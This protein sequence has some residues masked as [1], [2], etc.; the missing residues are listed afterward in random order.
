MTRIVREMPYFDAPCFRARW[1]T[2][3]LDRRDAELARD[4]RQKAVHLAVELHRLHDLGAK[5]LQRA[6]VVVQVHAG[7]LRD[8]P[9]AIIDG[10]RRLKNLSFRS[11]RQPATM[12]AGRSSSSF[13]IAGNVA[14]DRSA[15]RRPW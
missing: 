12:S 10:S 14:A 2:T 8:D 1:F 13:T 5:H 4:G 15:D 11:L 7:R 9:F 3:V 6:A